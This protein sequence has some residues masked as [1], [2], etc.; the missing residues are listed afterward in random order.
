MILV[1]TIYIKGKPIGL[2]RQHTRTKQIA[3]S[4]FGGVRKLPEREWFCVDELKEAVIAAYA[5]DS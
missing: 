4:P 3:F 5:K 2:I 1:E